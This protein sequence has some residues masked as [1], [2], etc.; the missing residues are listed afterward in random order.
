VEVLTGSGAWTEAAKINA[1]IY[2]DIPDTVEKRAQKLAANLDR[3][4]TR[5]EASI[6]QGELDAL[7]GLSLEWRNTEAEIERIRN[8]YAKRRSPFPGFPGSN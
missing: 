2:Q 8:E 6:A 4:A 3:I 7:P 5:F 1:A